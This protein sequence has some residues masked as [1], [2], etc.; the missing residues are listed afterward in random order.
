M[1]LIYDEI[2]VFDISI[3]TNKKEAYGGELSVA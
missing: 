1:E 2:G 3:K